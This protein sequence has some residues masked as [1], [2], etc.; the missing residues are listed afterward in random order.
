MLWFSSWLEMI[1]RPPG[2]EERV[3]VEVQRAAAR[4]GSGSATGSGRAGRRGG[5]GRCRGRRSAG[6][7]EAAPRKSIGGPP[8]VAFARA[9]RRASAPSRRCAHADAADAEDRGDRRGAVAPPMH[10]DPAGLADHA[11]VRERL[12]AARGDGRA[13]PAALITATTARRRAVGADAADHVHRAARA[14][15]AEACITG[16]RQ[17]CRS[18]SPCRWPGRTG[19][20]PPRA[21]SS[22][23]P[24]AITT[25]PAER[26]DG[27]V[28]QARRAAAR[29]CAR[30]PPVK[31]TMRSREDRAGV[32]ADDVGGRP[33]RG[34]GQVGERRRQR[35]TRR[36][37]P[38]AGSNVPMPE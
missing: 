17:A 11:G 21:R 3:V 33:D 24:P 30:A 19:R 8:A 4:A 12:W 32:A 2:A 27:G 6:R 29:R 9:E 31:A 5:C 7:R 1:A 18:A 28:A 23:R 13:R 34:H 38:V 15:P 37:V 25:L 16:A 10:Q 35:S 22:V 36:V 26:R 20:P 14:R